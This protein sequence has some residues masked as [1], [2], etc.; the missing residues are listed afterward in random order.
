MSSLRSHPK[1]RSLRYPVRND[2]QPP[3]EK[4]QDI[5]AYYQTHRKCVLGGEGGGRFIQ[6][7]LIQV[8]KDVVESALKTSLVELQLL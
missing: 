7:C 5:R 8:V 1:M 3:L 4:V 6:F 2:I